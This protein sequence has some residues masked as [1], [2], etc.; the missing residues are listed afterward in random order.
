MLSEMAKQLLYKQ[1]K[2]GVKM[3]LMLV[4]ASTLLELKEALALHQEYVSALEQIVDG[5]TKRAAQQ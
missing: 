5:E 1:A 4:E 3:P 2:I